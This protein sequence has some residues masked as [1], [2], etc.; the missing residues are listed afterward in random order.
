MLTRL[1][2]AVLVA[3]CGGEA[4]SQVPRAHPRYAKPVVLPAPVTDGSISLEQVIS[5][6][7]SQRSFR[8]DPLPVAAIGQ[9]L[10]AGQGI[11]SVDGK[12]TA[13]SAGAL[14]PLELYVVTPTEVMHYLPEGHRVETRPAAS[15]SSSA[16]RR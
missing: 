3:G 1:A 9:L 7:R 11:T 8:P 4:A 10:W 6:R 2:M 13:P 12:R 14:Y 16:L 15:G 5:R